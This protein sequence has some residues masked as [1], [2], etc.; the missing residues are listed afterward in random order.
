MVELGLEYMRYGCR[1]EAVNMP[2]SLLRVL[3]SIESL[4]SPEVYN[5]KI[6]P[7]A[8]SSFTICRKLLL[9]V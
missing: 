5:V 4:D 2:Q 1:T 9:T 7:C 8:L 3:L 6:P